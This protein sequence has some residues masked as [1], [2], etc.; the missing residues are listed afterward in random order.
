MVQ[1]GVSALGKKNSTTVFPRKSFSETGLPFWSGKVNSGALSWIFMSVSPFRSTYYSTTRRFLVA[2]GLSLLLALAQIDPAQIARSAK[3]SKGPRALGLLVMAPNGK[4]HLIPITILYDGKFY[5]AGEYKA[6]PVPMALQ[7]ETVYEGLRT[8]VSQ[9][10]F[11]VTA[12]L[13]QQST[14]TWIAEGSWLPASAI[15]AKAASKPVES[16]IPRGIDQDEGPPKLRHSPAKPQT[17]ES[18]PSTAPGQTTPPATPP[19]TPATS[20]STAPAPSAPATATAA[21]SGAPPAVQEDTDRP[22]LRRGKPAPEAPELIIPPAA[23]PA[24]KAAKSSAT[25]PTS[26][27]SQIQLIPAISDADGPDPRPYT[28]SL[29][30]DE[31]Q[32]FRTKMLALA[33]EEVRTYAK[34]LA[35]EIVGSA[36]PATHATAPRAKI[37]AKPVQ[38]SFHDVE[39]R[40]FD[41]SN[42]NEPEFVLSAKARLPQRLGAKEDAAPHLEYFVTLVA[43]E[44][45][46]GDLHKALA[47]VTDAQHLDV[48]PRLELI[49]AVDADGDGRGELLFRQVSDSG[50]AFVVYRVI[51][52]QLWPLFQGSLGE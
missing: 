23:K 28:Y 7:S 9:G 20:R 12:A 19:S 21:S 8:G 35:G 48:S 13:L 22:V 17:P 32:Q 14:N 5:D 10:L 40:A 39:L 51:G 31:E 36:P 24:S 16:S 15:T 49:D 29:T 46:N 26:P 44:D 27:A 3:G 2:G 11:T 25:L 4:A 45:V 47:N 43:R 37:T 34:Q 38:P 1:P 6:D 50:T 18:P 41:L 30:H 42:S 33:A 52:D